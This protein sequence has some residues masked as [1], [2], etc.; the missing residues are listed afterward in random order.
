MAVNLVASCVGYGSRCIYML[1]GML[2]KIIW[3]QYFR[4][5][6]KLRLTGKGKIVGRIT[7]TERAHG[8]R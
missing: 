4:W 1:L 3:I 2:D 6:L 5:K 8:A 7:P